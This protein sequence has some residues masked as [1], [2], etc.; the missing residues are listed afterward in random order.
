VKP[1]FEGSSK[2]ITQRSVG[3]T[4]AEVRAAA[5]ELL[6]AYPEGVL[7]EEYVDGVDVTVGWVEKVGC[8]PPVAFR[9]ASRGRWPIYDRGLKRESDAVTAEVPARLTPALC[10]EL[11][12]RTARIVHQLGLHDVARVD[13]R[14]DV[15]GGRAEVNALPSLVPER[16]DEMYAAARR[17][18]LE[19]PAALL[20]AIVETAAARQQ[21]ATR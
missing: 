10:E 16:D 20:G 8:L 6:R 18:G 7:L 17:V 5:L 11:R 13:W 14:V 3:G 4:R 2:G 19:S 1:N 21:L 15:E 9:Y 12:R